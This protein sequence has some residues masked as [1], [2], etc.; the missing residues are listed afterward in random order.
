MT[1]SEWHKKIDQLDQNII[2][3][4][5]KIKK[6]QENLKYLRKRKKRLQKMVIIKEQKCH[7]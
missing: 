2:L 7:S 6:I 4:E 1:L 3:G 5:K